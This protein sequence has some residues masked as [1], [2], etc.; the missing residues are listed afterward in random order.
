MENNLETIKVKFE[1]AGELKTFWLLIGN[2]EERSNFEVDLKLFIEKHKL[3]GN[4]KI[5]EVK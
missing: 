3:W 5:T 4:S 2:P 1:V